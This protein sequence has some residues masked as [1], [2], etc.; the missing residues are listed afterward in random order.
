MLQFHWLSQ[1]YTY[2]NTRRST[3]ISYQAALDDDVA[4]IAPFMYFLKL[5][6][7]PPSSSSVSCRHTPAC[8][9]LSGTR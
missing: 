5:L 2:N 8:T 1:A 3:G 4:S 9:L 6:I 7:T